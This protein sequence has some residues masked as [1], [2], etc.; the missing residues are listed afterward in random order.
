MTTQIQTSIEGSKFGLSNTNQV[1]AQNVTTG[2]QYAVTPVPT[3]NMTVTME[4][5]NTFD[6]SGIVNWFDD[7][8]GDVLADQ[9]SGLAGSDGQ[10]VAPAING[11]TN[12]GLNGVVRLVGGDDAGATMALNGSQLLSNLQ[13]R[14][15]DGGLIA[16]ARVALSSVN[17]VC[18]FFGFT[19]STSLEMPVNSA[20]SG[21]TVTTTA[22]D[23]VGFMY[24]TSMTNDTW[25][26][27]G[28]AADTDATPQNS[29]IAPAANTHQILRL[30][31]T[32]AG[33]AT[34]YINGTQVG[35]AMT[36]AINAATPITPTLAIFSR[37]TS[38]K[39][40]DCDYLK[41]KKN[42]PA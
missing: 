21:N 22:S 14:A 20:G 4:E 24:D 7:F 41:V 10:C 1:V 31:V 36:G 42:R 35:T 18:A 26:L 11:S 16:E 2:A 40:F 8:L 29:G 30:E 9:W 23:T 6:R 37:T 28:V 38:V 39:N 3:E 32:A 12:T 25:W 5:L 13:W 17:D 27:V 33:V 15:S 34:F 19:D